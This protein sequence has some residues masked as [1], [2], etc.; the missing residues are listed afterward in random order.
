MDKLPK[1]VDLLSD[2]LAKNSQLF[3]FLIVFLTP[4]FLF[5]VASY[6]AQTSRRIDFWEKKLKV[7][8]GDLAVCEEKRQTTEDIYTKFKEVLESRY[9]LANDMEKVRDELKAVKIENLSLQD[10][11]KLTEQIQSLSQFIEATKLKIDD[12]QEAIDS[13]S[14]VRDEVH[15][16]IDKKYSSRNPMRHL[17]KILKGVRGK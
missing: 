16:F 13:T 7:K 3:A 5:F 9:E 15:S 14:N 1:V 8:E 12:I 17:G 6:H 10:K 2:N 11:L 4:V